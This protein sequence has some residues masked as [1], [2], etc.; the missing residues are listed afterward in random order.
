MT[1]RLAALVF[2]VS[3]AVATTNA[4]A[5]EITI[6]PLK[7]TDLWTRAMPPGAP[8]G[9]YTF[10]PD[11]CPTTL[12]DATNW[13]KALGPDADKL[14]FYFMTVDPE[15]DTK[16]AIAEYLQAFDPRMIGLTGSP[17]AVEKALKAFRVYWR[18]VPADTGG[19]TMDHTA[20]VFMLDADGSF[21]GAIAYQE[22]EE[23]VLPKLRK[24]IA[25]SSP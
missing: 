13:M 23:E 22:P 15:R 21:A 12:F 11:V 3:A 14:K 16:A 5:H 2:L 25:G 24:L 17:D 4:S 9:G 19:Y 20:S 18:K 7:L 8:V 10:C 6:G 1:M